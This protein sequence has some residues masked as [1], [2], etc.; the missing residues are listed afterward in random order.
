MLLH[1]EDVS[2]FKISREVLNQVNP[3]YFEKYATREI[4]S[5]FVVFLKLFRID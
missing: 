2:F 5:S 1:Y 3:E 4:R